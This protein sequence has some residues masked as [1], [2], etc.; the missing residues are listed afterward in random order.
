LYFKNLILRNPISGGVEAESY[1][2]IFDVFII[3][4]ANDALRIPGATMISLLALIDQ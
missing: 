1:G 3:L 2:C 4:L